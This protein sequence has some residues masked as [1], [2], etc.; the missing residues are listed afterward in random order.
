MYYWRE[1]FQVT[2]GKGTA[3]SLCKSVQPRLSSLSLLGAPL[4]EFGCGS[5]NAL[6]EP[7]PAAF[8][9][10]CL[11]QPHHCSKAIRQHHIQNCFLK[12]E[13]ILS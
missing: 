5:R 6:F 12:R 10:E 7:Q 9:W 1:N 13:V 8:S 2:E 4:G 11:A 3:L